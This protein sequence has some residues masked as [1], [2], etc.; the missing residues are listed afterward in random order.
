MIFKALL[1][2]TVN[3]IQTEAGTIEGVYVLQIRYTAHTLQLCIYDAL[4]YRLIN[5]ITEK[6]REVVEKLQ[7]QNAFSI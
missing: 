6:A 5:A 7:T 4:K 3:Q 2:E 1:E